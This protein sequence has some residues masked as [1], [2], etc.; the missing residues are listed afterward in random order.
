V[1]TARRVVGARTTLRSSQ[2]LANAD[3]W[4]STERS[5]A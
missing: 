5:T 3:R 4:H 1:V 2:P